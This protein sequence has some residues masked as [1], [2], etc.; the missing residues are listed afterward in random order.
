MSRRRTAKAPGKGVVVLAGESSNDRRILAAFIKALHPELARTVVLTEISDPVRL[1]KKSGS[2]LATAAGI[3]VNK[4]R[5]K[6]KLKK[7]DLVGIAI[8]EDMDACPGPA[9]DNAR[10]MVSSALTN[11]AGSCESVYA[12]AA[13]ESEAWLLLFPD[14]F[15]LH[16]PSWKLPASWEGRDTARRQKPKEDLEAELNSPR[17]RESDGPEIA[18]KALEH[19]L[20]EQP[21]GTNRSY[22][23]FASDLGAWSVPSPGRR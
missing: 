7:G 12:L 20:I 3:L 1:R 11:A 17:F 18:T 16:R 15:P 10:R 13:A 6:A 19:G 21:K 22:S 2:E 8:H 9:Y 4:A 14:A 5:G 23:E